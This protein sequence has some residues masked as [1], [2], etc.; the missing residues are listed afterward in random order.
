MATAVQTVPER[1]RPFEWLEDF[2]RDELA[3]FPGRGVLVARMVI[4]VTIIVIV[5]MTLRIPYGAY[6]AIWALAIPRDNPEATIRAVRTLVISFSCS[7]GVVLIGSIFFS[8]DPLLRTIWVG[9]T[10]CGVFYVLSA[11][12]NYTAAARFG[13][14]IVITVP[15][16]DQQI[17]AEL[18]VEDTL[19]AVGAISLAGVITAIVE[20]IFHKLKPL[21]DLSESIDERL[22][23]VQALLN[24]YADGTPDQL[25]EKQ[26]RR[27]SMLGTSR[28]R[29]DL[30]R[31]GYTPQYA[32]KMS[33]VVAYIGRLVDLAANLTYFA[34]DVPATCR[35]RILR[36]VAAIENIRID[37][38]NRRVPH[39]Q[40]PLGGEAVE[41]IPL[42]VEMEVTVSLIPDLYMDTQD[43]QEFT[44]SSMPAE[45]RKGLFVPDA[46]SNSR[47][48]YFALRG[49]L[50]A[51]LCYAIYNLIAWPGIS[52]AVTTCY[53]TALTTIGASR[54]KQALRFSGALVGGAIAL[55]SQVFVLPL[56]DSITGFLL[57]L[58]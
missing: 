44:P 27:L 38:L 30:Q 26:I 49:G 6:G 50:A 2:L 37:L 9:G 20:V 3:P 32:E 15:V 33:A 36:L 58:L 13:Y 57:L 48:A 16:W 25:S 46:L 34:P 19:W 1:F 43:L 21:D 12:S 8:G 55:L 28:M 42:L 7:A 52:T 56:L 45:T 24:S 17:P 54:Q 53:L 22:E 47:H 23:Q 39:V 40:G 11:L 4:A 18:K 41:M 10:L 31:S 14:I 35:R 29:G 5:N 51:F